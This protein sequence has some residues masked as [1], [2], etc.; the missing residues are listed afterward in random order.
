MV[1]ILITIRGVLNFKKA[2]II[3]SL[4][5]VLTWALDDNIPL[6]TRLSLRLNKDSDLIIL[7]QT[8]EL[9]FDLSLS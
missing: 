2:K 7:R 1:T 3:I 4:G 6:Q 9:S 8:K 5:L